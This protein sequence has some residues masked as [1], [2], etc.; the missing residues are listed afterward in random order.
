MRRVRNRV[1]GE[2]VGRR[3]GPRPASGPG[4][5]R[6]AGRHEPSRQ[7][8]AEAAAPTN[9]IDA[10]TGKIS[11]EAIELMNTDYAAAEQKIRTLRLDRLSP[12]ERGRVEQILFDMALQ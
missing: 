6:V 9:D 2:L 7:R 11:N 10:Q 8:N 4:P 3:A 1:L 5:E 12:Y